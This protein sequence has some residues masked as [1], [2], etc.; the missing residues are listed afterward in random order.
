MLLLQHVNNDGNAHML[1]SYY[2]I[3]LI[4]NA[5][6]C[7][8]PY[9]CTCNSHCRICITGG[10]VIFNCNCI[11]FYVDTCVRACVSYTASCSTSSSGI[12]STIVLLFGFVL[13]AFSVMIVTE[14]DF[15]LI[16]V[17]FVYMQQ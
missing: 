15:K 14:Y 10:E 1:E 6:D 2:S 12:G 4:W 7:L 8:W 9:S 11:T 5:C 16:S 17:S 3:F 13:A